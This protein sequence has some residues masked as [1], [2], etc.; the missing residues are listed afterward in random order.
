MRNSFA[1]AMARTAFSSYK[2]AYPSFTDVH[3]FCTAG[4]PLLPGSGPDVSAT[5]IALDDSSLQWL[6]T[7]T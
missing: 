4:R 7:C 5:T 3:H 6:E 1:R 2:T